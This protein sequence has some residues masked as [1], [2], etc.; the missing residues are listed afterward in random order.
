MLICLGFI[1]RRRSECLF[2]SALEKNQI[3]EITPLS[4]SDFLKLAVDKSGCRMTSSV[5]VL[6]NVRLALYM[7]CLRSV[8]ER[9]NSL[10][11]RL[12][13]LMRYV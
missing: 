12:K 4:H 11:R 8:H 6:Q 7:D 13:G 2:E 5:H 3:K 1:G 10:L 9:P